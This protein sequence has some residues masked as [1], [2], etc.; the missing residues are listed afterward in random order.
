MGCINVISNAF[1]GIKSIAKGRIER[2]RRSN[3]RFEELVTRQLE[4][5]T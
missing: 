2:G 5:K 3:S 4:T 1:E